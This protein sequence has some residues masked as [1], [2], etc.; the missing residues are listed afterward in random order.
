MVHLGTEVGL[1]WQAE[2]EDC[3]RLAYNLH[4][5][6]PAQPYCSNL[7]WS[8]RWTSGLLPRDW[9]FKIGNNEPFASILYPNSEPLEWY[10]AQLLSG[11]N[12]TSETE[13]NPERK[14]SS[15]GEFSAQC[16]HKYKWPQNW[17]YLSRNK[18]LLNHLSPNLLES[19][20]L[21]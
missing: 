15:T 19:E 21:L 12:Y 14:L 13:G 2:L 5:Q 20:I 11:V 8:A 17:E 10:L 9:S 1:P 3:M 4:V 7:L 6:L 16:K 18:W